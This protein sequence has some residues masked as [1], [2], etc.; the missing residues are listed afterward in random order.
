[1]SEMRKDV[2]IV[3]K[4]TT[5]SKSDKGDRLQVSLTRDEVPK[6]IAALEALKDNERGVKLDAHIRVKEYQGRTFDSTFFFVKPIQEF[7]A[8]GAGP[9]GPGAGK[10]F[11]ATPSKGFLT[12]DDVKAKSASAKSFG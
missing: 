10:K 2:M 1:M 4:S 6:L 5:R 3:T 8:Q 9:G 11:P 12:A 7:G